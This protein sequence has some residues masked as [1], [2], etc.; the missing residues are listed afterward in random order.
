MKKQSLF[1]V[2]EYRECFK[3]MTSKDVYTYFEHGS[4]DQ[5]TL[6]DNIESFHQ[7][8]ILPRILTDVSHT[9]L[10]TQILGSE[11]S[12]PFG[13]SPTAFHK[14]VHPE[15]EL[16]TA[17]AA[18][19]LNCIMILS[20]FSTVAM[21]DVIQNQ[22]NCSLWLQVH[23]PKNRSI[24]ESMIHRAEKCN[25]KAIVV[26]VDTPIHPDRE[27]VSRYKF[28]LPSHL[29]IANFA[30]YDFFR[31]SRNDTNELF[32]E[33]ATW[34]DIKWMKSICKLP[35]VLKGVLSSEDAL[36]ASSLGVDGII[37]SNHGGRQLDGVPSTIDVLPSIIY[38]LK[39]IGSPLE[40][41]LDG[42]VRRGSDIFKAIALGAKAVFIGRP[43]IW[44]LH[45]DGAN[46]VEQILNIFSHEL[47]Q[48]MK[49]SGCNRIS[50]IK[51]DKLFIKKNQFM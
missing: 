51:H 44:G 12:L 15:G 6:K 18:N 40:V 29:S 14:I 19:K 13:F 25:F 42:G 7:I 20:S 27:A 31:R 9:S 30:Q 39:E 47:R 2:N 4:W 24:L 26:T 35:V 36:I 37:V 46:G 5:I 32:N 1:S 16:A 8:K 23:F 28:D 49:L 43:V 50:D 21:E 34:E 41:Y 48:T 45:Y 3:N 22:P 11:V 17:K 38:A 10:N 33:K